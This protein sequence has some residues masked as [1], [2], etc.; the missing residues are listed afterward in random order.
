MEL[1]SPAGSLE[2]LEVAYQ[3]GA[4]A[5]YIG[6][7]GFSLRTKA[8][9]IQRS[10]PEEIRR[11]KGDK[12]LYGALNMYFHNADLR[13]LEGDLDYIAQL[14]LDAIIVS[15][16]G[17]LPLLQ[18]RFPDV[19]MHLSTQANCINADAAR[20]YKNMGFSRIVPGRELSLIEISEIKAA[21]PELELE[22]FIH[23]AMCLAYSGRCFLSSWMSNRSGNTGDCS[24]SC[25][26]NY[27]LAAQESLALEEQKRPGQYYPIEEGEGYTTIMSS[28]DI[29]MIDHMDKLYEAGIDSVKIEG[30]MKSV[31]YLAM[32]TRAY[33]RHLD[34]AHGEAVGAEELAAYKQE[35][36]KVSHR[37]FSTGFYFGKEDIEEPNEINYE[38]SH[39]FLGRIMQR[40]ENGRYV[41]DVRN[42]ILRG[43][44]IE[45][46]GPDVLFLVDR[47]FR[48]FDE[49]GAEVEQIDHGKYCEIESQK[50]LKAGYI[51]RRENTR[52]H[53]LI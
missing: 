52:E 13:R 21:V 18:R 3:Y 32:V 40:L 12:K 48:M 27:R 44:E 31:Y 20:M 7:D 42:Q 30:R 4:D 35:L 8:D 46:I 19:E 2:K 36:Y 6:I 29:C 39:M 16:I 50:K 22:T 11:I 25:R 26:W 51:L 34:W 43:D 37:Q 45:F 15:D 33:R 47:N 1:L 23:G 10:D 14:P 49:N 28:K 24:H 53:R 38:R 41:I 9:G 17:A 5:A